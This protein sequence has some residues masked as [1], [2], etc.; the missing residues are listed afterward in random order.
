MLQTGDTIRIDLNEF[1][2]NILISEE[3]YGVGGS[4]DCSWRFPLCQKAKR[5][6]SNT[7]REM[8][9][10]FDKGMTLR[11]ADAYQDVARKGLPRDNH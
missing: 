1:S 11:G 4:V 2:A 8:V 7:F 9:E 3:E 5:R 10:P 6:G